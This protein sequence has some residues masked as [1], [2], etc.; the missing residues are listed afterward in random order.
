M[1][2]DD[3]KPIKGYEGFYEITKDGRVWS[4]ISNRFMK[5]TTASNGYYMVNLSKDNKHRYCTVHRLVA[6]TYLDN[7]YNLPQVNHIDGN[8]QN[9]DV[10]NLEW[11]TNK[12]NAQHAWDNGLHDCKRIHDQTTG[13]TY[14][15]LEQAAR[16]VG[17]YHQNIWK[18]CNGLR[19]TCMG[20]VFT[21]IY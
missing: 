5:P 6:L 11:V 14:G 21:Y 2:T 20:H 13:F 9:N 12:Q 17:G 10:N 3:L 4:C 19:K 16:A 1:I 8:K 7:P 18:V 15:N